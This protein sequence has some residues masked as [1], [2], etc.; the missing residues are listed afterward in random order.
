V[1]GRDG[2]LEKCL[3]FATKQNNQECN[4][5][6]RLEQTT[7]KRKEKATANRKQ[8][9]SEEKQPQNRSA[10]ER[11]NKKGKQH[12]DDDTMKRSGKEGKVRIKNRENKQRRNGKDQGGFHVARSASYESGRGRLRRAKRGIG[13]L[14]TSMPARAETGNGDGSNV[15]SS[16]DESTGTA[17]QDID[18]GRRHRARTIGHRMKNQRRPNNCPTLVVSRNMSGNM[19][20]AKVARAISAIAARDRRPAKRL[21]TARSIIPAWNRFLHFTTPSGGRFRPSNLPSDVRQSADAA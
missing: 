7:T 5:T 15:D 20:G 1:F 14:R 10:T 4:G 12:G 16:L 21:R 9:N 8:K 13:A 11:G 17:S 19:S 18:P 3:E 6:T 2:R